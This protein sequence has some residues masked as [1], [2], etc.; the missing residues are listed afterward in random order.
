MG[1]LS[2]ER[3]VGRGYEGYHCIVAV[4]RWG[5]LG[6]WV[7]IYNSWCPSLSQESLQKNHILEWQ[8]REGFPTLLVCANPFVSLKKRRRLGEIQTDS[9][10]SQRSRM[11]V[12]S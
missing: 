6:L 4:G 3:V 9:S 5:V 10:E 2:K 7:G 8:F 12:V 11:S 1:F